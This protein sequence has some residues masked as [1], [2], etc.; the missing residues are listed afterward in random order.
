[1]NA[2]D[3]EKLELSVSQKIVSRCGGKIIIIDTGISH[4]YGGALS[5]LE[6]TYTLTPFTDASGEKK[7]HE[8]EVVKA[9]YVDHAVLIADDKREVV[10]DFA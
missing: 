6:I 7:W 4:A 2:S 8:R 1:M 10:G 3:S 9:L 5:A